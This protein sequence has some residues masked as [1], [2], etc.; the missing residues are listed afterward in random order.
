MIAEL[1][2]YALATGALLA[3][4]ARAAEEVL[5][6]YRLPLRWVWVAALVGS[7]ALPAVSWATGGAWP[8]GVLSLGRDAASEVNWLLLMALIEQDAAASGAAPGES[9]WLAGVRLAL[10]VAWVLASVAAL[11]AYG[12]TMARV[13]RGSRAWRA[14]ELAGAPVLVAPRDGPVVIGLRKPA[15]VVPEW[16]MNEPPML[17]RVVVIHEREHLRAR[18]HTLLAMAPLAAM[19]AP[20]NLPVWWMLRRLRL[21]VELDCDRRVLG[22]GIA[23]RAYGSVLLDVAGRGAAPSFAAAALAEPRTFLERRILAMTSVLPARRFPRA[24]GFGVVSAVVV[25]LSC[26]TAGPTTVSTAKPEADPSAVELSVKPRVEEVPFDVQ[27]VPLDVKFVGPGEYELRIQGVITVDGKV[28]TAEML[29]SIDLTKVKVIEIG[30]RRI[31]IVTEGSGSMTEADKAKLKNLIRTALENSERAV[32]EAVVRDGRAVLEAR[33]R[34]GRSLRPPPPP[35]PPPGDVMEADKIKMSYEKLQ[36]EYAD[37]LLVK[38]RKPSQDELLTE[39]ELKRELDGVTRI[40]EDAKVLVPRIRKDKWNEALESKL[41]A[42]AENIVLDRNAT[43]ENIVLEGMPS[44]SLD[45][46][47]QPQPIVYI[48]GRL[49]PSGEVNRLDPSQIE[50]IEVLKGAAALREYGERAVNG[51]ILI[52]TKGGA[53][54]RQPQGTARAR[55]APRPPI[56]VEM[57]QNPPLIMIDGDVADTDAMGRLD[58]DQIESIEVVKGAAAVRLY[59]E[60]AVNGAILVT[61]K[62]R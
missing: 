57:R 58:R 1:M 38:A 44:I 23:A 54:D 34:S 47:Q 17:Q 49:V 18:D 50:H 62:G 16:L 6:P 36:L 27:E 15:I 35:P 20:W 10:I 12:W 42:A 60:R 59:G 43:S 37:Q 31:E 19:A 28:V 25:A 13:R 5:R 21:A 4:A 9:A 61:T 24:L 14:A 40:I 45:A 48:D 55:V 26:E 52:T 33:D 53:A 56:P 39:K 3:L 8:G 7:V 11:I 30:G 22:H 2:L 32:N 41:S 29:E 46:A 51:V